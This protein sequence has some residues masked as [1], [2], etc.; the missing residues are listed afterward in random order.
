M[1]SA[2]VRPRERLTAEQ[3]WE[4]QADF[5]RSELIDGE[6]V[7]MPPTGLPH[8]ETE[9]RF[10]ALLLAWA[11]PRGA[12]VAGGEVGYELAPHTVRGADVCVHL[13]PPAAASGWTKTPPDVVVEVVSPNDRWTELE[14]KAALWI[15]FGVREVWVADPVTRRVVVRRPDGTAVTFAAGDTLTSSVLEGFEASIERLMPE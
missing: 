5:A 1:E 11:E 4:R 7:A 12:L 3:Y 2:P 13:T 6:V 8:G 9:I 14:Q 10:G 15:A